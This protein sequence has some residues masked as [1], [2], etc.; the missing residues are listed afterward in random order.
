MQLIFFFLAKIFK[1]LKMNIAFFS[2]IHGNIDALKAAKNEAIKLGIKKFVSL[3]D[4]V[5]YYYNPSEVINLLTKIKAIMI[6][7]NHEEILIKCQK[8][9]SYLRKIT[10]KY[11]SGHNIAIE[12][13]SKDKIQLLNTLP[14][15]LKLDINK[16]ESILLC[17]GSPRNIDEYLYPDTS[18]DIINLFLKKNKYIA[19]GHSHYQ[20]IKKDLEG[21][22][23]FNPG[24]IGQPR[25]KGKKG[26]CWCIFCTETHK[27]TFKDTPYDKN[28]LINKVKIKDPSNCY[29]Y[30]VLER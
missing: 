17:H 28:K 11:G 20:F 9:K 8:D 13:L 29:N 18:E 19:C 30:K 15:Q 25:E 26:A 3:G 2:D 27:I 24:S 14:E 4:Y 23:L 12:S 21:N 6:K 7:G 22:F 1:L 10:S 5:G 16:N